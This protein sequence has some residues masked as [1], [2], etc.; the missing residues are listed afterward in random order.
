MERFVHYTQN[1]AFF[2]EQHVK[3]GVLAWPQNW[4]NSAIALQRGVPGEVGA[5]LLVSTD[6]VHSDKVEG[7]M[8]KQGALGAKTTTDPSESG[9]V[10]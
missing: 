5:L 1:I 7:D 4:P 3:I 10:C 8:N 6:E 9:T 2:A